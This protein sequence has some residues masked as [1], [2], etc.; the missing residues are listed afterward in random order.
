MHGG[1]G[2]RVLCGHGCHVEGDLGDW[3]ERLV[4][5]AE[6][7]RGEHGG[8]VLAR[9]FCVVWCVLHHGERVEF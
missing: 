2:W 8:R 9:H 3:V 7:L 1:R 5:H 6:L 4:Q